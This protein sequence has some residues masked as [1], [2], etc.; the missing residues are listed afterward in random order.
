MP[1]RDRRPL[2]VLPTGE[3]RKCLSQASQHFRE[4]GAKAE[5][6]FFG[7]HRKAIGVILSYDRYVEMLD[8]LDDLHAAL[9]VRRRDRSDTGE[10]LSFEDLAHSVGLDPDESARCPT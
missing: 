1:V 6:L 5:P 3:A 2:D 9:E 4:C 10:R 7:P 8:A